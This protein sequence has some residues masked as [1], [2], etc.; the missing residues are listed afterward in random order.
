MKKTKLFFSMLMSL[1]LIS[2]FVSCGGDAEV[3][4]TLT[5]TQESCVETTAMEKPS[6]TT[7][8]TT[9]KPSV[10]QPTITQAK[11]VVIEPKQVS[12]CMYH[13]GFLFTTLDENGRTASRELYDPFT[14]QRVSI[15][16]YGYDEDGV[17]SSFSITDRDGETIPYVLFYTEGSRSVLAI[18]DNDY[19]SQYRFEQDESGKI[20]LE[21]KDSR[22]PLAYE[23][24]YNTD[25]Y[26]VQE[27]LYH[28][29]YEVVYDTAYASGKAVITSEAAMVTGLVLTYDAEGYPLTLEGWHRTYFEYE[30]V[31]RYSYNQKKLCTS[32]S[33]VKDSDPYVCEF[34]YNAMGLV[35]RKVTTNLNS[36]FIEQESFA[37]DDAGRLIREEYKSVDDAGM[38]A[39]WCVVAYGYDGHGRRT[40]MLITSYNEDGSER[41]KIGTVKV[42]NGYGVLSTETNISYARDGSVIEK[43]EQKYIYGSDNQHVI[44]VNESYYEG[45]DLL[46]TRIERVLKNNYKETVTEYHYTRD[47]G[48]L[49]YKSELILI[50]DENDL[51][52]KSEY[53]LYD[54]KEALV[55]R[56]VGE[57][58]NG[59]L[60]KTTYYDAA[61]NVVKVE[62][63]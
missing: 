54:A 61:G 11:P 12:Y 59:N 25:G 6:E 34:T 22:D 15:Y 33:T 1:L 31:N 55:S 46:L 52:I 62:E 27:K 30:Y 4:T 44:Q 14:M 9:K 13:A 19:T 26:L 10:T 18:A 37:Y 57:Y 51:L 8:Q 29:D 53:K 7:A 16:T 47:D 39:S 3:T 38:F 2:V 58:E 20:I 56:E 36:R 50:Y 49:S 35:I 17:L 60:V 5:S 63:R 28:F 42:Y 24:A 41:S 21:K 32:I 23:F 45:E 40:E 48:S 43:R